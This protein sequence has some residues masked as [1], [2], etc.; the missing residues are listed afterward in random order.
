MERKVVI[1]DKNPY[2]IVY[3]Y[4]NVRIDEVAALAGEYCRGQG[5]RV[6]LKESL[7][8]RNN[9]RLAAFDCVNDR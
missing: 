9:N 5:K 8:H 4:K 6:Y 3:E 7:T 1:R 2:G